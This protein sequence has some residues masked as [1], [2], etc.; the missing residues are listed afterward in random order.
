MGAVTPGAIT[1]AS[2]LGYSEDEHDASPISPGDSGEDFGSLWLSPPSTGDSL[3][4]KGCLLVSVIVFGT[5][6]DQ[7]YITGTIECQ[8]S[9][10]RFREIG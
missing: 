1:G 4:A 10:A 9:H 8:L 6:C 2:G 7:D 3:E 5:I